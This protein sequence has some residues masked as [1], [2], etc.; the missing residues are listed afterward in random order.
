[1]TIKI[2]VNRLKDY[3]KFKGSIKNLKSSFENENE[4]EEEL[5]DPDLDASTVKK[6]E[7][8]NKSKKSAQST[9]KISDFFRQIETK[10]GLFLSKLKLLKSQSHMRQKFTVN[11]FIPSKIHSF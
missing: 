8:N 9:E 5:L 4:N 1:M 3:L 7:A 11:V 10:N 6:K 2:L